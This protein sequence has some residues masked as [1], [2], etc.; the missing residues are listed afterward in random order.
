MSGHL[1]VIEP[2]APSICQ[3]GWC[4]IVNHTA[5]RVQH[6]IE[7]ELICK[8]QAFK[9]GL[10]ALFE[11]YKISSLNFFIPFSNPIFMHEA[12]WMLKMGVTRHKRRRLLFIR[13]IAVCHFCCWDMSMYRWSQSSQRTNVFQQIQSGAETM[14]NSI[15]IND[16]YVKLGRH[17]SAG[18][19]RFFQ[20]CW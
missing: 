2:M 1:M 19:K 18:M 16:L 14:S 8:F 11:H 10:W 15:G 20:H 6:D 4:G 13:T 17:I 9:F 7:L 12:C 3:S 5:L